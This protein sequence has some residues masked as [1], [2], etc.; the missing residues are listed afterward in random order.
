VEQPCGKYHFLL[1][2]N[3]IT[4]CN[5]KKIKKGIKRIIFAL[6]VLEKKQI[7]KNVKKITHTIMH[8]FIYN[9]T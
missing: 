2:F 3:V 9:Y 5:S 8:N 1:I 4:I 7:W 6:F